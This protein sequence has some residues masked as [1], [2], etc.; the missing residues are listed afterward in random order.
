MSGFPSPRSPSGLNVSQVSCPDGIPS[1][2]LLTL[3][4]RCA[5]NGGS[6]GIRLQYDCP[7]CHRA[8]RGA[9]S[10]QNCSAGIQLSDAN[11]STSP[12]VGDPSR[13]TFMGCRRRVQRQP[14]GVY[15]NQCPVSS[16]YDTITPAQMDAI[17]Y[18]DLPGDKELVTRLAPAFQKTPTIRSPWVSALSQSSRNGRLHRRVRPGR[19]CE[20]C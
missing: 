9:W 1:M 7:C 3:L 16:S 5:H 20:I 11:Q 12:L 15:G 18:E 10:G 4:Y 19:S 17:T 14:P 13:Y 6:R 8:G 2:S